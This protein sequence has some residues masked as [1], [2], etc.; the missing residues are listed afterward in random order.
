MVSTIPSAVSGFTKD[1]APSTA[2][3]PSGNGR[4][5]P[6]AARQYSPYVAPP[7]NPTVRPSSASA[8]GDVPAATTT[9]APSLPTVI[10]LPTRAARERMTASAIGAV[11][12]GS[13]T[14][15]PAT[16]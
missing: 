1:D 3:A 4:H 6:G 11:T 9:P 5:I 13:S 2:L 12:V 8:S 14:D 10:V 7:T 15:P 16:A